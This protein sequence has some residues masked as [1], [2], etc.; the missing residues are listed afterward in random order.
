[1]YT[2]F[3]YT[4][5]KVLWIKSKVLWLMMV[6]VDSIIFPMCFLMGQA[7]ICECYSHRYWQIFFACQLCYHRYKVCILFNTIHTVLC[8]K[9]TYL[10]YYKVAQMHIYLRQIASS[11]PHTILSYYLIFNE[12]TI[13]FSIEI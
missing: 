9:W 11:P 7:Q 10:V 6:V 13:S 4:L 3:L 12:L 2:Y 1:M 5:V 8:L